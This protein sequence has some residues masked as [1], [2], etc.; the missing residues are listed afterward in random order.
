MPTRSATSTAERPVRRRASAST[1]CSAVGDGAALGQ[2]GADAAAAAHQPEQPVDLALVDLAL[3]FGGARAARRR[4]SGA[5][6]AS[7][8]RPA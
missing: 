5:R 3:A 7:R 1:I 6:A 8:S 2:R 4:R